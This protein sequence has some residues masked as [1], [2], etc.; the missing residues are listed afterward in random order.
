MKFPICAFTL[1]FAF[2]A[3]ATLVDT[4][5]GNVV[6]VERELNDIYEACAV[7]ITNA[8]GDITKP[9]R[10]FVCRF[11]ITTD[12]EISQ[13]TKA[14]LRTERSNPCT[15]DGDLDNGN[16]LIIF[17]VRDKFSS[18][19]ESK[20]CLAKVLSGKNSLKAVVHTIQ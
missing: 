4:N 13:T 3:Q 8:T 1:F 7:K 10:Y 2:T 5:I 18:V 16:I 19:E 20:T 9:S 6:A 12:N 17:G 11:K 14:F 15:A